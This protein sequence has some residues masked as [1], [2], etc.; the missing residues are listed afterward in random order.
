MNINIFVC[1]ETWLHDDVDDTLLY[2]S[3]FTLYRYDRRNR[4]GGGCAAWVS[5]TIAC[6]QLNIIPPNGIESLFLI[7]NQL[8]IIL[9]VIYLPPDVA[10]R[11]S[12]AINN[13]IVFEVDKLLDRNANFDVILCGDL[14]TFGML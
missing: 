9:I 1:C 6:D 13:F 3:G 14:D 7:L 11:E 2:V 10:N 12:G 4:V 5:N 8:Q